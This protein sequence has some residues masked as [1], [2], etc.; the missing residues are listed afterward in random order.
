M[1]VLISIALAA[2]QGQPAV[3]PAPAQPPAVHAHQAQHSRPA[4]PG[5]KPAEGCSCC[6][7]MAAGGKM[8][9]C[10]KHGES[11]GGEHS[12]HSATR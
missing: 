10:A 8:E 3:Q 12:G 1:S 5:V 2:A 6:K 7:D 9:C 11:H 4:Q